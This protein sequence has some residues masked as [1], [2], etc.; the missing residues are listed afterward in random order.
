[1]PIT[2]TIDHDRRQVDAVA[3]GPITYTDVEN[4]LLAER[5]SEGLA[6]REFVDAR[7]ATLVFASYPA[8]VRQMVALIR[9]LGKESTLG[10]TAV[11]VA[12]DFAFGIMRMLEALVEDVAEIR[13]FREEQLAR[14]WLVAR[15][16]Q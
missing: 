16:I 3:I 11:L 7:E 10:P 13:P 4:H 15:S 12:D 1:M 6:Y 2:L 5:N 14:A 8:Q 9:S